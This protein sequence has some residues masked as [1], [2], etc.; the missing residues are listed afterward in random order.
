MVALSLVLAALAY[1][2]FYAA[3][4][5]RQSQPLG[6]PKPLRL[7]GV[8]LTGTALVLSAVGTETAGGPVFVLTVMMAAA[9][10]LAMAGPFLLPQTEAARPRT[11]RPGA[12]ARTPSHPPTLPPAD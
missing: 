9:A 12:S 11:P 10:A 4:P 8:V 1:G 5:G 3:A 6:P 7:A 2:A